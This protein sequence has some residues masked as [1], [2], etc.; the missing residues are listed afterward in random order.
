MKTNVESIDIEKS[1]R[2]NF[3]Y[4][5]Y[6]SKGSLPIRILENGKNVDLSSY[7]A[8]VF[9][10]FS[11]DIIS[12]PCDI[13]G[14]TINIPLKKEYFTKKEKIPFEITLENDEQRVTTFMMY[15]DV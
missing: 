11:N 3:K 6:A 12:L 7:V 9:F 15:L 13:D 1:T 4:K 14:N 10:K 8:K 5:K 2:K